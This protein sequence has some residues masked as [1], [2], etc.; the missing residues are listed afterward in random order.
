MTAVDPQI[1][2][3]LVE[4]GKQAVE[5]H[6]A[7]LKG[8]SELPGPRE[9]PRGSFLH[10]FFLPFSLIVATLRDRELRAA[11]LR[12]SLLRMLVVLLAAVLLYANGCGPEPDKKP[13]A[14]LVVKADEPV[15]VDVP[16]VHVDIDPNKQDIVVLGQKVAV[17]PEQPK[18]PPKPPPKPEPHVVTVIRTGWKWLLATIAFLSALEGVI[19]FFTRRYDDWISH[20]GSRLA[21]IKPEDDIPKVPIV[22]ADLPWLYRKFKRRIR[23]YVVFAAGVPALYPLRFVPWGGEWIFTFAATLWGWYWL[24]VF[25][26]SKSAHAWADEATAPP[27]WVIRTLNDRARGRWW[28]APLRLYGRAWAWLTRGVNPAAQTFERTPLPF[29][30]LALAR[31]VLSLPALYLLARP[32]VPIAAG[33]LCAEGDPHDRFSAPSP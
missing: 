29:L 22:T 24:G 26:A 11:Y 33:R 7:S 2:Q 19:V 18:P 9:A 10:G 14:G 30:G 20:H 12:L 27:P 6:R 28:T 1:P 25:T 21:R 23:G 17:P 31:I 13:K 32:I 8:T 3:I 15:K 16:G 5:F 4:R